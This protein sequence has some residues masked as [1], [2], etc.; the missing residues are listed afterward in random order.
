ELLRRLRPDRLWAILRSAALAASVAAA[1]VAPCAARTQAVD[2]PA[3]ARADVAS[4]QG[5]FL[6]RAEGRAERNLSNVS[7]SGAGDVNGDGLTD[8][9]VGAPYASPGGRTRAG[10]S[11]VVLGKA[12]TEAIE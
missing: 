5:G 2:F 12:G 3:I 1:L 6:V 10:K 9:L 4:G 8:L 11:Y 7:V